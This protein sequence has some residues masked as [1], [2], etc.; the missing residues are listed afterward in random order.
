MNSDLT[1]VTGI[2]PAAAAILKTHG[3]QTIEDLASASAANI[4]VVPGFG[5]SR[6]SQVIASAKAILS[7]SGETKAAQP[8]KAKSAED[9]KKGKKKGKKKKDKKE[10]KKNKKNKKGKKGGKKKGKRGKKKK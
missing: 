2:G 3:F 6:A 7:G 4:M 10:S 9:T 8:S 1:Q 5:E